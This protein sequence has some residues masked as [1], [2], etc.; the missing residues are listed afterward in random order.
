MNKNC[1]ETALYMYFSV[2][3][4]KD[5]AQRYFRSFGKPPTAPIPVMHNP[6]LSDRCLQFRCHNSISNLELIGVLTVHYFWEINTF[7]G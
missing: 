6:L 7:G 3:L 5:R 1:S 4:R 2:Y